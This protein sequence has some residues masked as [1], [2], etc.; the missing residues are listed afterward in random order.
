MDRI[1][2]RMVSFAGVACSSQ[3]EIPGDTNN[4][5]VMGV[6]QSFSSEQRREEVIRRV[7]EAKENGEARPSGGG[8]S[9]PETRSLLAQWD[10]LML[11]DGVLCRRLEDIEGMQSWLQP[12]VPKSCVSE[13]L[14]AMHDSPVGGHLGQEKTLEKVRGKFHWFGLR[15]DVLHWSEQC[16]RCAEA[17][18]PNH[19]AKAPLISGDVGYPMALDIVGPLPVTDGNNRVILVVA[20]YFTKW[21]E[22]FAIPNHKT[23][24]VAEKLVDE[25]FCRFG[26][27]RVIRTDAGQ[28]F[29]SHLF[30]D[31][32]KLLGIENPRKPPYHPQSD[33]LVERFN[34]TLGAMLRSVVS[35]N[36][37][38][39]DKV[40]PNVLMAYRSSI[41][42]S[43]RFTPHFMWWGG[44][45]M[46]LPLVVMYGGGMELSDTAVGF[47]KL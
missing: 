26:T 20:D 36:Q 35:E 29:E 13:G 6:D 16:V 1:S 34:T 4:A 21:V 31:V 33:G 12:V 8:H 32:C 23:E 46:S 44:R 15:K 40:L 39:W 19:T 42:S 2:A 10:R 5:N 30:G 37:K 41:H 27:P 17:K 45:E 47:V 3:P 11:K 25:V 18:A 24:T 7:I 22:A 43:T 38:D 28:D 14:S 9:S